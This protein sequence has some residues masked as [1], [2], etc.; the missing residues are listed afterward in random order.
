MTRPAPDRRY[1]VVFATDRDVKPR[2]QPMRCSTPDAA[3]AMARYFGAPVG[4]IVTRYWPATGTEQDPRKYNLRGVDVAGSDWQAV[5]DQ[6]KPVT[7][8]R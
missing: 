8:R 2:R 6:A 7:P 4:V 1:R 5:I 3:R